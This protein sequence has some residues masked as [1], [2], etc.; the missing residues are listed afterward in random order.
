MATSNNVPD[1]CLDKDSQIRVV[2]PDQF[3]R[4][5]NLHK[6]CSDFV[7]KIMEF[8][9]VAGGVV[10]ELDCVKKR[11]RSL[12]LRAL[13]QRCKLESAVEDRR[14]EEEKLQRQLK[15]K[16]E[17]LERCYLEN[18][19]LEKVIAEQLAQIEKLQG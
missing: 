2:S 10:R 1:I 15:E 9:D 13:G 4:A 18:A 17:E 16:N 7:Q 11:V 14:E 5:E 8:N 6:E 12:K 19:S 3:Q